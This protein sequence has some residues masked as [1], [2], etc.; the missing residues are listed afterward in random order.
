MQVFFNRSPDR[1]N[2]INKIDLIHRDYP[3]IEFFGIALSY[4]ATPFH[5][6][7]NQRPTNTTHAN[8]APARPRA[9]YM[10]HWDGNHNP[11]YYEMGWDLHVTLRCGL[12]VDFNIVL[13]ELA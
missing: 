10:M 12:I 8:I 9:P 11:I 3:Q 4:F 13:D 1:S 6:P 5:A 2:A 7:P